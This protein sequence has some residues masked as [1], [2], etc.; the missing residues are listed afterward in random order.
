MDCQRC[1]NGDFNEK[2]HC[3]RCGKANA[4]DRGKEASSFKEILGAAT[5]IGA[6]W[7]GGK[8][9]KTA[10]LHCAG[11]HGGTPLSLPPEFQQNRSRLCTEIPG[12]PAVS[13][14]LELQREMQR[15]QHQ[16]EIAKILMD[17]MRTR[18]RIMLGLK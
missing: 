10:S 6:F 5:I 3:T 16:A 7:L 1:G 9:L 12:Q 14:Q 15:R 4:P 11:S 2:G 18:N 8:V 13:A 17:G